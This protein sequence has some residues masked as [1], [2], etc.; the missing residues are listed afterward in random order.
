MKEVVFRIVLLGLLQT[1]IKFVKLVVKIVIAVLILILVQFAL[2]LLFLQMGNAN[3]IQPLAKQDL[4]LI[5]EYLDALIVQKIVKLA[6]EAYA[7]LVLVD[8]Y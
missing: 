3:I 4:I 5:E 6:L 7:I 2:V 8:I 1:K